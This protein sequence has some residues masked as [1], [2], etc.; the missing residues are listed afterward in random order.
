MS[1][2]IVS[3]SQRKNSN[4]MRAAR[5]LESK[6]LEKNLFADALVMDLA[7]IKLP[8][9]DD[10]MWSK[11]SH[12]MKE[13]WPPLAAELKKAEALVFISPEWSGMAAPALHN[14]LLFC[15]TKELAHKPVLLTT[16][17]TG[18][19]GAYPISEL[20]ASGY[21]NTRLCYL[22]EHLIIRSAAD[23]FAEEKQKD[24]RVVEL[25]ERIDCTLELLKTY[26]DAFKQIRANHNFDFS[27]YPNG[28]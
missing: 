25:Q 24:K 16:V 15:S 27:K 20:R 6:A 21:K 3:S 4:S 8:L 18:I 17:S 28:M 11:K 7:E 13:Q 5:Y 26:S 10:V 22:P 14:F 12:P 23:F 2:V 19:G 1:L 9:W